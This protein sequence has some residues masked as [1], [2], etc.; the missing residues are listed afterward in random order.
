MS[1]I[2]KA[3]RRAEERQSRTSG[4]ESWSHEFDTTKA[5]R[6]QARR[7][8]GTRTV[9]IVLFAV[10]LVAVGG[11][12]LYDQRSVIG[13]WASGTFATSSGTGSKARPGAASPSRNQAQQTPV[14]PVKS[15]VRK[16]ASAPS[17]G[18]STSKGAIPEKG[19]P[20]VEKS[21]VD[22]SPVAAAPEP[23]PMQ[24]PEPMPGGE[25]QTRDIDLDGYRLE[26][27]VWST[28]PNSRF[29]VING[30]IVRAGGNLDDISVTAIERDSVK[31]RSGKGTGELRFTL[32]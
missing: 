3:L 18:D 9:F 16:T 31:V 7:S 13:R 11:W 5:L 8:R 4:M 32:E 23:A 19:L 6:K 27:I 24:S 22:V 14:S 29:A 17:V 15:P 2:L 30:Q 21:A 25:V 10:V 1:S 12:S 20:V 28:N 26:A